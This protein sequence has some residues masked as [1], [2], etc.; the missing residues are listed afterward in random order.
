VA[1]LTVRTGPQYWSTGLDALRQAILRQATLWLRHCASAPV[2]GRRRRLLAVGALWW[3]SAAVLAQTSALRQVGPSEDNVKAAYLLR[4]LN[5]VE[6]PAASFAGPDTPYMIGVASDDAVLGELQRQA[7]GRS[8]NHRPVAVRRVNAGDP[9][10]GLHVLFIGDRAR[11][12][13]LLHQVHGLPVL[14][15]TESDGA[16]EQGSMINFLLV[17]ERLRFE[18]ALDPVKRSG[19]E[20]NTRLLSVAS[21]VIKGTQP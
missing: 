15:V 6:W 4:F 3:A 16:L 1:P 11:Q 9:V 17:D 10:A 7:I 20:L 19:L 13:A 5:Y 12:A 14:A 21:T 18:V 2:P 8:V